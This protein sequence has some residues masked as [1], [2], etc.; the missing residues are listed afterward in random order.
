MTDF[1][2][3]RRSL[4]ARLFSTVTTIVS[5]AV[6]VALMLVLLSMKDSGQRA[7]ERGSGNMH[8]LVSRDASPLDSVLNGVFYA[9]APAKPILWPEYER[10][11]KMPIASLGGAPLSEVLEYAIPIQQGDSYRGFP[12]LATTPDFF[13]RFRPAAEEA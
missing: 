3:I 11:L 5:V 8:L 10:L 13:T 9:R 12:T 4:I 7:F 6:A 2:I 1:P